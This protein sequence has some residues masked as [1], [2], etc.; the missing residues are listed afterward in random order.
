MTRDAA[1]ALR[2]LAFEA[3]HLTSTTTLRRAI[4]RPSEG[5]A[6]PMAAMRAAG[7]I[8][9]GATVQ[10]A[11]E[12]V[13]DWMLINY[14]SEI[15]YK[16]AIANRIFLAR[17]D[18]RLASMLSEFRVG[19]S[20]ADS[21]VING[22]GTVYEIKTELDNPAKLQKQIEDYRKAF[23][24][25]TVVTYRSLAKF[26][27]D[28]TSELSAGV[29]VLNDD[30]VLRTRRRPALDGTALSVSSM[31]RSLR[32]PEYTR[33]AELISGRS[34]DAPG[35]QHFSTCLKIAHS[36]SSAEYSLLFE[37]QLRQRRPRAGSAIADER[38]AQIRNQVLKVD[39]STAQL[40]RLGVWLTGEV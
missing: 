36:V 28:A 4:D 24:A 39:P 40:A 5:V 23:R 15:V 14:R 17:H 35:V 12:S 32:K 33:I 30:G 18:W 34:I 22:H 21:V 9:G 37:E 6:H 11:L 25:V 16:N 31:M 3:A 38:F 2:R 20:I 7:V 1:V 26:Y 29:I 27:L 13:M 8:K 10:A 19:E